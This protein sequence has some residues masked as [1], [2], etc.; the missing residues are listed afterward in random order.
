MV[1]R[2]ENAKKLKLAGSGFSALGTRNGLV[3]LRFNYLG[4]MQKQRRSHF[5]GS[6]AFFLLQPRYAH[7]SH[8]L[9]IL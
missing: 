2:S 3:G 4:T 9:M 5:E 6:S 1:D 7:L 8:R